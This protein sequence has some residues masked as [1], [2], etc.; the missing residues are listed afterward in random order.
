MHPW[1]C[2]PRGHR[3]R[4]GQLPR[5]EVGSPTKAVP[6]GWAGLT[7]TDSLL[8]FTPRKIRLCGRKE[9]V[10]VLHCTFLVGCT[11]RLGA[12]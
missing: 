3:A 1:V 7:Y 8:D 4:T 9:E 11:P 6:Q 2:V 10:W 12:G 5:K